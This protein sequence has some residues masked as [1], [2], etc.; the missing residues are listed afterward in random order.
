DALPISIVRTPS[1][2]QHKTPLRYLLAQCTNPKD[3]NGTPWLLRYPIVPISSVL[4]DN[5]CTSPKTFRWTHRWRADSCGSGRKHCSIQRLSNN[6]LSK[7]HH[8]Y[9]AHMLSSLKNNA[10]FMWQ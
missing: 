3:S 9:N 5:G 4:P 1:P 2:R 10:C 8:N 6:A 7:N